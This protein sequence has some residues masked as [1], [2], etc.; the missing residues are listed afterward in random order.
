MENDA[1]YDGDVLHS[2]SMR[3][4]AD[5]LDRDL[6]LPGEDDVVSSFDFHQVIVISCPICGIDATARLVDK[7][8]NALVGDVTVTLRILS[9]SCE[10]PKVYLQY[11]N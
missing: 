7:G 11:D 3:I 4:S 5:D 6:L 2:I 1:V 9:T 10:C 8:S